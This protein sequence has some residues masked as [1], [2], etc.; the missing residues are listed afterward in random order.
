M[1]W[2]RKPSMIERLIDVSVPALVAGAAGFAGWAGELTL[3]HSAGMALAAA[4]VAAL[5]LR[6]A[7][8]PRA[9][10]FEFA[11][12]ALAAPVADEV[13]GDELL[14]E[15][16]LDEP[17]QDSRVVRLFAPETLAMP[18]DLAARIDDW[19]EGARTR[20]AARPGLAV[21]GGGHGP[22]SSPASAALH[23]ALAD[24]KRS[25]G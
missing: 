2:T 10:R 9:G 5:V 22:A 6:W 1:E 18:G 19:L 4:A 24:I 3:G 15:D 23:A 8:A 20:T 13:A 17:G 16:R 21:N 7:S 14:L 25:L 12:D 11:L